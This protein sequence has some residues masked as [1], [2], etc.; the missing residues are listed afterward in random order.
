MWWSPESLLTP[1]AMSQASSVEAGREEW[2]TLFGVGGCI[3]F[4]PLLSIVYV[5]RWLCCLNNPAGL[6]FFFF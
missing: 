3:D 1:V 2:L 4:F 5:E 6:F